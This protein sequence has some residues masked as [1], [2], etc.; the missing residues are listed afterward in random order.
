MRWPPLGE[1]RAARAQ[2]PRMA[3]TRYF[4]LVR[5]TRSA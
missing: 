1:S 4:N 5:E 2:T 3:H